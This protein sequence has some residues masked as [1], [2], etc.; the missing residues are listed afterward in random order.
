MCRPLRNT[1]QVSA[2]A[3]TSCIRWEM[4]KIAVPLSRNA[5]SSVL[6]VSTSPAVSADVASS[7]ISSCGERP[8]A[9]A[10][11]TSWRRDSGRSRTAMRGSMSAQPT[12]A[13]SASARRRCAR[14]L[15]NPAIPGGPVMQML[16]AT[17]RSGNSDSSWNTQTNPMPHGVERGGEMQRLTIH[18]HV[19]AVRPDGAGDDLDQRALAGA[20]LTQHCVDGTPPA[21]KVD[22][23]ECCHPAIA[24]A[25]VAQ[26]QERCAGGR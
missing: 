21:G 20:V 14:W 15:M 1:E 7:M 13:N 23:I 10:N 5:R 16:S 2:S 26:A 17:L 11:S 3:S 18:L 25:Y 22:A 8:S 6:T 9:L 4:N 24:L 19:A 12:W